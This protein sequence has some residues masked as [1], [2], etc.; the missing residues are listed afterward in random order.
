MRALKHQQYLEAPSI[1]IVDGDGRASSAMKTIYNSEVYK[2]HRAESVTEALEV[3]TKI[4]FTYVLM[5]LKLKDDPITS[6]V[7]K[8]ARRSTV[9]SVQ[10]LNDHMIDQHLGRTPEGVFKGLKNEFKKLDAESFNELFAEKVKLESEKRKLLNR[11]KDLMDKYVDLIDSIRYASGLQRSL[12]PSEEQMHELFPEC[13]VYYQPRDIVSGDFYWMKKVNGKI[14]F[15]VADCSGHGVPGAM[16]T[17]LGTSILNQLIVEQRIA[18]TG[19]IMRCLNRNIIELFGKKHESLNLQR[20]D[21][22]DITVCS[23]DPDK[24]ILSYSSAKRPFIIIRDGKLSA[25]KGEVMNIGDSN[26]IEH[27]FTSNKIAIEP[28]DILYLYSDGYSDQFGGPDDKKFSNKSLRNLLLHMHGFPMH[29]QDQI[30][31]EIM[32]RW[33][34]DHQRTDDQVVVGIKF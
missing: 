27:I 33:R 26:N 13:F 34:G 7:L 15:A 3:M 16:M 1:L 23:Y 21:G 6:D 20:T 2:I 25:I 5:N 29:E 28:N 10:F 12:M 11:N 14:F 17:M 18:E 8:L 9:T 19:T 4:K 30:L 31:R 24:N 32:E 22:M